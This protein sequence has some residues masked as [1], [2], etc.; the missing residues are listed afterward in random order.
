MVIDDCLTPLIRQYDSALIQKF[1]HLASAMLALLVTSTLGLCLYSHLM[2]KV[3][4]TTLYKIRIELFAKIRRLPL[5][6]FGS[7]SNGGSMDRPTNNTD[8]L[9]DTPNSSA[10][11][12]ISSFL[13]VTGIFPSMLW[14]SW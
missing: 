10:T 1:L 11:S 12:S 7:K 5:R 2:F 13:T 3:S 6:Y 8:A 9:H 4:T 14:Y